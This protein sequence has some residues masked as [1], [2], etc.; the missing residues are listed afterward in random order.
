MDLGDAPVDVEVG[1]LGRQH[2]GH[3]LG[4]LER[5]RHDAIL[6]HSD[7]LLLEDL[8]TLPLPG[9]VGQSGILAAAPPRVEPGALRANPA[10]RRFR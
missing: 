10:L 6:F 7:A 2:L 4:E 5:A 1:E 3:C 9:S 8:A